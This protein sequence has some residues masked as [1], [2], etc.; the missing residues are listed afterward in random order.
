MGPDKP[1][2]QRRVEAAGGQVLR[3]RVNGDLNLS[4]CVGDVEYKMNWKLSPAHQMVSAEAEIRQL[5]LGPDDEFII[6]GCDGV[7][8]RSTPQAVCD[9]VKTRLE[10]SP[11]VQ[12][13]RIV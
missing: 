2:E 10:C 8:E 4:R 5:A 13:S 12:I 6:L 3:G 9:F 11:S 7:W 1:S